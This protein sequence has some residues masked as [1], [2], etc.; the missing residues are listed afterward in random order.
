[1]AFLH[2]SFQNQF[3]WPALGLH[4]HCLQS[5]LTLSPAKYFLPPWWQGHSASES[6]HSNSPGFPGISAARKPVSHSQPGLTSKDI[7]RI[8]HGVSEAKWPPDFSKVF[9][10]PTLCPAGSQPLAA[11]RWPDWRLASVW[12]PTGRISSNNFENE[13][14][15]K[16][17]D[18]IIMVIL[19]IPSVTALPQRTK[20]WRFEGM[21]REQGQAHRQELSVSDSKDYNCNCNWA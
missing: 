2:L 10:P 20:T 21:K 15:T 4:L 18:D 11:H 17:I 13:F 5:C 16:T 14:Q 8:F 19:Q 3:H 6:R 7:R 9:L 12:S 1:M